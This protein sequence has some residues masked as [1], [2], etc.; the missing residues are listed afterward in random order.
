[1]THF[2]KIRLTR[3]VNF[4]EPQTKA[5]ISGCDETKVSATSENS[6]TDCSM[7]NSRDETQRLRRSAL[8]LSISAVNLRIEVASGFLLWLRSSAR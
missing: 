6:L 7:P 1:M 2:I 5:A 4:R 8:I 3:I